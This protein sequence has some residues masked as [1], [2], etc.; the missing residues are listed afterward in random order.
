MQLDRAVA[1]KVLPEHIAKREN[2]RPRFE[3]GARAGRVVE[4]SEYLFALRYR[5]SDQLDLHEVGADARL[6]N[7]CGADSVGGDRRGITVFGT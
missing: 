4:S 7:S 3:C 5:Q 2:L 1:V 6:S